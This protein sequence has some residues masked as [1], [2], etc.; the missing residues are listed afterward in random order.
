M[1]IFGRYD[2]FREGFCRIMIDFLRKEKYILLICVLLAVMQGVIFTGVQ[3]WLSGNL[4]FPLDD[5]FIHLQY[6]KQIALGHYYAYQNTA[7]ASNRRNEFSLCP[8]SG[9]GVCYW[10]PG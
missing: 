6:G 7:A 2:G 3:V 8:S 10:L 9:A 4:S 1:R 5:A